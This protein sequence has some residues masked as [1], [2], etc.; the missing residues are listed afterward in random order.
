MPRTE[1]NARHHNWRQKVALITLEVE[2]FTI[3]QVKSLVLVCL[4]ALSLIDGEL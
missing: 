2:K 1:E 4:K 3:L